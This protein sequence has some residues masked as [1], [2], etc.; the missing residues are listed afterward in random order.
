MTIDPFQLWKTRN[1]Q[2]WMAI[3]PFQYRM[4]RNIR[5][6]MTTNTLFW[7]KRN[8]QIWMILAQIPH[9]IQEG[10]IIIQF[11]MII[12]SSVIIIQIWMKMWGQKPSIFGNQTYLHTLIRD[13][14][15][16]S[17]SITRGKDVTSYVRM[18]STDSSIAVY[19]LS[20]HQLIRQSTP[21][22]G[23]CL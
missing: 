10:V 21:L 7:M 18:W 12:E 4:T 22:Y 5:F 23:H 2:I 3:N 17:H 11:W 8:I 15:I 19:P 13:H 20:G 1:I 16:Q 14:S 9:Y 6:W